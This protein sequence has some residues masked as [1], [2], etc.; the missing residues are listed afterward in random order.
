MSW[1][2]TAIL[3]VILLLLGGYV[4]YESQQEPQVE[5]LPTPLPEPE[6]AELVTA[7]IDEVNRLEVTRLEDD[8][9]ASFSR[10]EAGDWFQTVPTHTAV[11]SQTMNTQL[12]G[13]VNLR[14]NR[15]LPADANPLSAYG[16]DDPAYQIV[17]A[18]TRDERTVRTTL[19]VG[20]ETPAGDAYYVQKRGDPR[21]HIV[22]IGVIQNMI[23]LLDNPPVPEPTETPVG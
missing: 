6:R 14:S 2:T 5:P 18:T 3:L 20:N 1:R 21:V 13:L 17:L 23:D 22:P 7:T 10:D 15:T 9:S 8:V 4:Y 12:T 11:I 19:L 16:L